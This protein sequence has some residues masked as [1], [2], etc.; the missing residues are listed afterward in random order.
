VKSNTVIIARNL[1]SD[2]ICRLLASWLANEQAHN[3]MAL[4]TPGLYLAGCRMYDLDNTTYLPLYEGQKQPLMP[5]QNIPSEFFN[6]E[7]DILRQTNLFNPAKAKQSVTLASVCVE[8]GFVRPHMDKNPHNQ[9]HLLMR[10]NLLAQASEAGGQFEVE[11]DGRTKSF[12][13]KVGDVLF[14]YADS[15]NHWT[16]PVH[17]PTP[18]I[19]ISY[20]LLVDR[21]WLQNHSVLL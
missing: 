1:V 8:N 19:L 16:T 2:S 18:R 9:S 11:D 3:R 12:D 14:F 7:K 20:P 17:G 21:E 10:C 15:L 13:M 5:L 6:L 4:W